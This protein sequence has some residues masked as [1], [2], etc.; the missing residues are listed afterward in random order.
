MSQTKIRLPQ[1]NAESLKAN[2]ALSLV[3][4]EQGQTA[5]YLTFDTVDH[6]IK[7]GDATVGIWLD[8]AL[9][10]ASFKDEDN[11]I[12]DS[13]TAVA[14]QQS[15]K[16]Y[17]DAQDH[18]EDI[19]YK[20]EGGSDNVLNLETKKFDYVGGEGM[21]IVRTV[22]GS[23]DTLTFSAEDAAV[24]AG[25]ANKGVASFDNAD[26]SVTGGH[27]IVKTAGVDYAQI[28]D[29]AASSVMG[30]I[31]SSAGA[32]ADISI[33]TT[34]VGSATKLARADAIKAYA[35]ANLG[36]V[37]LD[38]TGKAAGHAILWDATQTRWESAAIA[39]TNFEV[40]VTL[41]DGALTIGL[42][43]DVTIGQDLIVTRNL[44]VN[45]TQFKIDGE[46]VV[47]NDTL[48]EMGTEGAANGAPTTTTTKDL[49][50]LF[51]R[52]DAVASA[53]QLQFMGWDESAQKFIMR[54]NVTETS[55][56]LTGL[57]A[58]AALEVGALDTS[59][60]ATLASA[61]VTGVTSLNGN[62]FLG[63]AA[64]DDI[65][66]N[67]KFAGDLLPN[68][69]ARKL[70]TGSFPWS[71]LNV[72]G[73]IVVDDFTLNGTQIDVS[74]AAA[75]DQDLTILPKGTGSVV[76]AKVDINGGAIDATAIGAIAPSTGVFT[77][78]NCDNKALRA[79]VLNI[80]SGTAGAITLAA[81]DEFV[82]QDA[83]AGNDIKKTTMADI[84]TYLAANASDKI[85]GTM[86]AAVVAGALV[87][88]VSGFP[89]LGST[90]LQ[91]VNGAS[92]SAAKSEVYL[93]GMLLSRG[94]DADYSV[95]STLPTEDFAYDSDA[96][97]GT[98]APGLIFSLPLQAGDQIVVMVR[99]S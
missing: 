77:E 66:P 49:G 35:D 12:S 28:Q 79:D 58:A 37:T 42:P 44:T 83:D 84:Q 15:I 52:W 85:V 6:D 81:D 4:K 76:M 16:A 70:G 21:D 2:T 98:P 95:G 23:Y 36:G 86:T 32:P 80:A 94:A 3:F 68:S 91:T 48:M 41:A 73:Q 27:V 14:S 69:N 93:N 11:M 99:A 19:T 43:S 34:F 47:M 61:T 13:A 40:D 96:D 18:A 33:E 7:V 38:Q 65:T 71:E 51:H 17:V 72:A 75:A 56:I 67:G 88:G 53:A 82:V 1:L 55:G 30:V 25:S 22:V 24:G 74:L 5:A 26:F 39:G 90:L 20:V 31:G 60:L 29:V 54:S 63:D 64:S 62:V 57:G 10:G 92:A 89:T 97:A 78:L 45:G 46:T 59:G 8:G 9:D 50:L 87:N